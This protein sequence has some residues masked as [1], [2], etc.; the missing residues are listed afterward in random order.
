VTAEIYP[1]SVRAVAQGFT[2]NVGRV[3]SAA[4]PFLVGSMAYTMTW[5]ASIIA[6]D[7]R[8][9]R[10]PEEIEEELVQFASAGMAAPVSQPVVVGAPGRAR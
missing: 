5:G 2:F 1:T 8:A 3:G 10:D 7:A 9:R 6:T 4:A